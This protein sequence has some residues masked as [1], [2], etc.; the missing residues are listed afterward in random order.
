VLH[1]LFNL[2]DR[3]SEYD[4]RVMLEVFV[5]HLTEADGAGD[6]CRPAVAILPEFYPT[7]SPKFQ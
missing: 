7:S 5:G 2:R 3:V 4:F 1:S 6:D